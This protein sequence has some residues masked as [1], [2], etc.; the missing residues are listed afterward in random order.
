MVKFLFLLFLLYVF[1]RIITFFYKNNT[2]NKFNSDSNKSTN[3]D[4]NNLRNKNTSKDSGEFIEYEEL[5]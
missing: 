1:Y 5:D 3:L 2:M 4:N